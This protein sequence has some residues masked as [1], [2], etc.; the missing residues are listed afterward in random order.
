MTQIASK[1]DIVQMIKVVGLLV[2]VFTALI[3]LVPDYVEWA[4]CELI[5]DLYILVL[6]F[7]I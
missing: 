4:V 6:G 1:G 2:I 7:Y 5:Q 3:F